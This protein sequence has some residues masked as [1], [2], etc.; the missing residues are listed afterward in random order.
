MNSEDFLQQFA[1]SLSADNPPEL[2]LETPFASLDAWWDSLAVVMC[3]E[4]IDAEYAVSLS[5]D[6]VRACATLGDLFNLI[7]QR[8]SA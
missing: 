3:L 7:S 1:A 8:R 4:M 2:S 6:E 5:G